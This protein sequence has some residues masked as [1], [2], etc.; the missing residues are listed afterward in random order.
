MEGSGPLEDEALRA[1]SGDLWGPERVGAAC[2]GLGG[3]EGG[4]GRAGASVIG[5]EGIE[6]GKEEA[7]VLA[8]AACEG[9]GVEPAERPW[10]KM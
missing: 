5:L 3:C 7:D 1:G 4:L 8:G 6:G 2:R 10:T 9:H